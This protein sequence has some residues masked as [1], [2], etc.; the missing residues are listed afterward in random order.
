MA[1]NLANREASSKNQRPVFVVGCHRSG[2]NLLYDM[3]LSAGGFAIYRGLL[4]V[5]EKLIPHCGSLD[6]MPNR[7]RAIGVFLQ[8]EAFRRSGLNAEHLRNAL[9]EGCRTGGD[10]IRIV[11]AAVAREQGVTRWAVYNPDNILRMPAIKRDIPDALFVHI[12]RDGRDIALSLS[13]MGG[14]SPLP[15]DRSSR[16]LAATALY[17]KWVV[18][19]GR[20]LGTKIGSDYMEVHYED[21]FCDPKST[22]GHL[23]RSL[24]H[25]L[26]YERI[27]RTG[28]GRIRESNSSFRVEEQ[29]TS[30]LNRWKTKLI[31]EDVARLEALVGDCLLATGYSLITPPGERATG[32]GEHW[33]RFEYSAFLKTKLWLKS[34]TPAGRLSDMSQLRL[35][36]VEAQPESE[37]VL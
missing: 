29:Q 21:L 3:L 7:K 9:M 32:L 24:D 35:E 16:S 37:Q 36:E 11:M 33:M 12:I 34:K 2:T 14:F 27:Q 13:K 8:S 25:D 26:D 19:R 4:P 18:E 15:W 22:L 20:R 23:S 17:W 30:P 10:F 5:Y 6:Q 28:L 31:P 1:E